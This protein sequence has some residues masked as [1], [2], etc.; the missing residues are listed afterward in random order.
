MSE[1]QDG[2]PDDWDQMIDTNV[3]GLLYVT[4]AVVPLM[5]ERGKGHIF[6]IGSIAAKETYPRGNVYCGTKHA[7]DSLTK[8][9]RID[10]LP[11]G[12]KV[13]LINPGATQTEF[14][15]VRFKGDKEKSEK[16]YDG[17][18]PLS[19]DDIAQ[20]IYFCAALPEHVNVNDMLIM[21][22]AQATATLFDKKA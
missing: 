9:L 3:K 7:V 22:A 21:P 1:I 6:N 19:G 12:I 20:C 10:L 14:S 8:G 4:K 17:Y 5:K 11:Y 18:K 15:D 2:D 16:V 13:S